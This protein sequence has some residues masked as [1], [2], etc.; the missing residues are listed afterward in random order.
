MGQGESEQAL[1]VC[2]VLS[3]NAGSPLM[4]SSTPATLLST[5]PMSR[6]R[7]SG[8]VPLHAALL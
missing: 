3:C 8:V 5:E 6:G 2:W 4:L 7:L 1:L